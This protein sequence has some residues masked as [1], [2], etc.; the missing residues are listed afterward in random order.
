M[1]CSCFIPFFSGIFPPKFRGVRYVD[2]GITDNQPGDPDSVTVS[3]WSGNSDICPQNDDY[4]SAFDLN[5]QNTSFQVTPS[6]LHRLSLVFFPAAP[7]ALEEICSDGFRDTRDY[8]I[9]HGLYEGTD[10]LPVNLT[11]S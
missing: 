5:V 4:V 8:L 7:T 10:N 2:G 3:P 6:N 1:T 11:F 9:S